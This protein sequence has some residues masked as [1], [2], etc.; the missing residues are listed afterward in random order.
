MMELKEKNFEM[1]L[2]G[3]QKAVVLVTKPWSAADS[4]T[5][6]V[7]QEVRTRR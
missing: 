7:K 1:T 6:N 5:V 3:F 4:A 2:K